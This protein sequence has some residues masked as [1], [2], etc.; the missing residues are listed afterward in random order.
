MFF[1]ILILKAMP[2]EWRLKSIFHKIDEINKQ[3]TI[4][5]YDWKTKYLLEKQINEV[6]LF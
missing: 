3:A 2:E 5:A 4:E 1:A 6:I